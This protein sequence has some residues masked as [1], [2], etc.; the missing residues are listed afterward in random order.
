MKKIIGLGVIKG[1]LG[2]LMTMIVFIVGGLVLLVG[3]IVGFSLLHGII[4]GV[5]NF[6]ERSDFIA[7]IIPGRNVILGIIAFVLL[8][9]GLLGMKFITPSEKVDIQFEE[10]DFNPKD[11]NIFLKAV[12][13]QFR[14]ETRVYGALWHFLGKHKGKVLSLT[15]TTSLL[16]GYYSLTDYS[17]LYQDTIVKHSF[18]NP[19]GQTYSWEDIEEVRVGTKGKRNNHDYYYTIQFK[20]K[21]IINLNPH[22]SINSHTYDFYDDL[23]MIDHRVKEL[24]I[25]KVI[26]RSNLDKLGRGYYPEHLEKARRLFED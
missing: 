20:D 9:V 3:F 19:R 6:F 14:F 5:D 16:L 24:G 13:M 23:L 1:T 21:T 15:L 2:S 22:T 12:Y 11:L 10:A 7:Y 4:A 25:H 17:I 26:D 18:F 8:V